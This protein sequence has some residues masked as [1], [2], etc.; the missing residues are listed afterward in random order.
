MR[1]RDPARPARR[2]RGDASRARRRE[3]RPRGDGPARARIRREGRRS[4]DRGRAVPSA[5][6]RSSPAGEVAP[7]AGRARHGGRVLGRGKP[8]RQPSD[9]ASLVDPLVGTGGDAGHTFPGAVVPFGMV[10]FSPV[11]ATTPGPGGYRYD[12]PTVRGLRAHA[13]ERRRV[14]E[15]RQRPD[16]AA[17]AARSGSTRCR[18]RASRTSGR[19]RRRAATACGST[20][21]STST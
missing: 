21:A 2:A 16:H 7:P 4:R 12:D 3:A 8:R 20:P 6:R 10:Q 14:L 18:R 13:A 5:A 17:R 15:P 1:D 9:P 11:S 19:A